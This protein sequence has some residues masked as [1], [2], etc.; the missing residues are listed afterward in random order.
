MAFCQFSSTGKMIPYFFRLTALI[1]G[2]LRDDTWPTLWSGQR[3]SEDHSIHSTL[4]KLNDQSLS[5]R[6]FTFPMLGCFAPKPPPTLPLRPLRRD[7][8][9]TADWAWTY[10]VFLA[11]HQFHLCGTDQW[12]MNSLSSAFYSPKADTKK[13]V[14]VPVVLSLHM[15][16]SLSS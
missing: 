7:V 9:C 14:K 1:F 12:G 8:T 5:F 10:L 6:E 4:G 13:I 11:L 16:T 15:I 3:Q 2:E